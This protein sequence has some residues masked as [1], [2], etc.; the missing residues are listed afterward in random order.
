MSWLFFS[1][2][3]YFSINSPNIVLRYSVGK[4]CEWLCCF[5]PASN[6][7]LCLCWHCEWLVGRC[8]L[9]IS[10]AEMKKLKEDNSAQEMEKTTGRSSFRLHSLSFESLR[11]NPF[12]KGAACR[13]LNYCLISKAWLRGAVKMP[14][15]HC[16][17]LVFFLFCFLFFNN[18]F[19]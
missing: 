19:V 4:L 11:S 1:V 10:P 6:G 18:N 2:T 15:A 13:L 17:Y 8:S 7:T 9:A 5:R 16:T 14:K 3:L 12:T